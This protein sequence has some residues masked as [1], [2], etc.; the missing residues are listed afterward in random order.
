MFPTFGF[1]GQANRPGSITS[2][3]FPLN[4]DPYG[5]C[6]GVQGILGAYRQALSQWRLSG[7]TLFAPLIRMAASIAAQTV[8]ACPPKYTCLLI[9]TDGEIMDMDVSVHHTIAIAITLRCMPHLAYAQV[10]QTH[11]GP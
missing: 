2:H 5:I 9:L 4:G 8:G 11:A 10:L 1:G 3:C 7:P 6:P